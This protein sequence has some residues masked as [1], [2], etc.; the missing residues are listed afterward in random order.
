MGVLEIHPWGSRNDALETPDRL[1][2]DLDP[3]PA[4]PWER[5]A[6]SAVEV[7]DLLKN[8][9]LET[10]VKTTGGKGIHVVAPVRPERQWPEFKEFAR[11]FV[12]MMEHANPKLYLTK[13]TKSARTGRIFLDYLR[14]ERGATAVAPFSPRARAGARVAMPLTWTELKRID[15][16]QFAAANYGDWESRLKR[17]PWLEMDSVKQR[18][19]DRASAA[20]SRMTTRKSA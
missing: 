18:L 13:M 16:K 5:L 11:N 3:D 7:R 8:L 17:D 14:N 2:I 12:L 9:G 19:T 4:L 20:V 6:A 10:F 1:I 15:P